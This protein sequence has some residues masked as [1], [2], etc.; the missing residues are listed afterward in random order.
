MCGSMADIQSAAAE[1]RRGKK[2]KKEEERRTNHSVKIYMVSLFHKATINNSDT[3][4]LKMITALYKMFYLLTYLQR[5][6]KQHI[7]RSVLLS[8]PIYSYCCSIIMIIIISVIIV[9]SDAFIISKRESLSN[10]NQ[11]SQFSPPNATF[12][13]LN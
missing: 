10:K 13:V 3:L 5:L 7:E 9:I 1:I 12:Q 2:K 4:T 8:T 11:M 6:L